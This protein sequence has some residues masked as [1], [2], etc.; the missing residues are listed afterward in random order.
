MPLVLD[1]HVVVDVVVYG[2]LVRLRHEVHELVE[3]AQRL[4]VID[5]GLDMRQVPF[6]EKR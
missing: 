5:G 4:A 1:I 2:Q 6:G 3:A